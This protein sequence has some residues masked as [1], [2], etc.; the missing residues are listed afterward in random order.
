[1]LLLEMTVN[2]QGW[3]QVLF[4]KYQPSEIPYRVRSGEPIEH[5]TLM[6][7]PVS[8]SIPTI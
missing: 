8:G 2:I 3:S 5:P 4:H 1:M 7:S 6:L